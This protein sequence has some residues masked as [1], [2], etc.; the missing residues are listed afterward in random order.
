MYFINLASYWRSRYISP[1][2]KQCNKCGTICLRCLLFKLYKVLCVNGYNL[3][4]YSTRDELNELKLAHIEY[5]T[6]WL[7]TL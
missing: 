3:I 6:V 4:G 5:R 7:K 1:N 2:V